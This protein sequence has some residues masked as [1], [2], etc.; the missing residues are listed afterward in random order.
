MLEHI[1]QILSFL[2]GNWWNK[3]VSKNSIKNIISQDFI[4]NLE[5]WNLLEHWKH[6]N[7]SIWFIKFFTL[8]KTYTALTQTS[9]YNGSKKR[10]HVYLKLLFKI[11]LCFN[12]WHLSKKSKC[13]KHYW[14]PNTNHLS[15]CCYSYKNNDN[16]DSRIGLKSD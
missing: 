14:I 13:R 5:Q 3:V 15:N 12:C 1:L 4:K 9:S 6:S 16:L 2:K 8:I 11:G 7:I 10:R